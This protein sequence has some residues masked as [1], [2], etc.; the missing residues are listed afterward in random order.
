MAARILDSDMLTFE[1]DDG[2]P[3]HRIID[4]E[5]LGRETGYDLYTQEGGMVVLNGA[6][7]ES[8]LDG[9]NCAVIFAVDIDLFLQQDW[10][11]SVHF[12]LQSHW[13]RHSYAGEPHGTPCCYGMHYMPCQR[14][15]TAFPAAPN[16]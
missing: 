15:S 6:Y 16:S 10:G 2:E 9:V 8:P 13:R 3:A 1:G 14:S 4:G 11:I 7:K 12:A 5:M